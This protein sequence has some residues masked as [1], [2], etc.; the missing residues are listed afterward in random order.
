MRQR[1]QV[2]RRGVGARGEA[3]EALATATGGGGVGVGEVVGVDGEE[4]GGAG[5]VLEVVPLL[6][7]QHPARAPLHVVTAVATVSA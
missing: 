7:V 1:Q 6:H 5:A 3:E 2:G 4:E